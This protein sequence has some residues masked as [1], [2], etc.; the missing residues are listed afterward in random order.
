MAPRPVDLRRRLI[1]LDAGCLAV[2][3]AVTLVIGA[4]TGRIDSG[5]PQLVAET[6]TLTAIGVL[7]TYGLRLY[8]SRVTA[9]RSVT[10][11]R[12]VLVVVALGAVVWCI[13][14]LDNRQ[15]PLVALTGALTAFVL[16]ACMRPC[17]DAWVT[18]Q[19]RRGTINRTVVLA[20]CASEIGELAELLAGHPEL[21]YR[22][23]GYMS[24]EP[25][26]SLRLD[27]IP[28]LGPTQRTSEAV[29]ATGATGAVIAANGIGSSELNA[30]VRQLH[31]AGIHV[32]LS[33]GLLRMDRRRVRQLP[34]AHEPFFYLEPHRP[35]S[36]AL[37]VKR[38]IDVFGASLV[39]ILTAPITCLAALAVKLTSPGPVIFHQVRVG[40][41]GEK[42][43]IRK[44]R[45]MS[46]G[47]EKHLDALK[48]QN[49]RSGPLFKMD[50]DPRVTKVGR[51]LRASSIDE[52]PQLVNV[53]EG[54][55][56]LVGPRPA[57]P[58][59]VAQFDK[60][61]LT[62]QVMRPGITGLWQVE[63]RHNP[64]FYAYRHL[65]LF[66][67]ENWSLSLDVA[68]LVATVRTLA[69]DTLQSLGRARSRRH[70]PSSSP[71]AAPRSTRPEAPAP[72]LDENPAIAIAADALGANP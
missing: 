60:E 33:S 37:A 43:V 8:Q 54:T 69:G 47:A 44:F 12:Q 50:D 19:R 13:E 49:V 32:H 31:T 20:G 42:V 5:V 63:A 41:D 52:L 57:L 48:Q 40:Q 17:F 68:V 35:P 25:S 18:L 62:R 3:W 24:D 4:S 58:A 11:E 55:L 38:M 72:S 16:L 46:V 64:S 67:V 14:R 27:E 26:P 9:S 2:A 36:G 56:S 30:L 66:Y 34:M 15:A 65:D 53:L 10:L 61:L 7:L 45:T 21:G 1:L 28:W 51:W 71:A 39:L 6:I 22:P 23:V 59:E 29:V 70:H